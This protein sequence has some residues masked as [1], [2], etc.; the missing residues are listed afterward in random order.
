MATIPMETP[1]DEDAPLPEDVQPSPYGEDQSE[2]FTE[3]EQAQYNAFVEAASDLIHGGDKE[4]VLPEILESLRGGGQSEPEP[5]PYNEEDDIEG[6]GPPPPS[7]GPILALANTAV[8]ICQKLDVDAAEAGTPWADEVLFQG[9]TEVIEM[10]GEIAEVAG[11]HD[12]SEDDLAGAFYQAVDLYRPIAI[13]MGRTSEEDLKGQFA[14]IEE[15]GK[16]GRLDQVMAETEASIAPP[17][18]PTVEQ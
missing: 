2:E 3:E 11:I 6:D 4:E 7:N 13:E 9:A 8:Q 15:A 16:D 17:V 10:L 1:L 5:E 14:E 12:Y 18:G